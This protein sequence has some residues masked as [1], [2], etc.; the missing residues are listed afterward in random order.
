MARRV[1]DLCSIM[2]LLA[3]PDGRDHTVIGMPNG[4]PAQVPIGDLRVAF[5]TDNGIVPAEPETAAV[6]RQAAASLQSEVRLMQEHRPPGVEESYEHEMRLIGPDGGDGLRAY[7]ASIES[8]RTHPLLDGWLD[9]LEPYRTTVAGFA[10]YW[11]DLDR[12]R[13]RMLAF[14]ENYDAILSPVCANAALPHGRSIEERIFPGFS[15][16]M[17][18]N[19]TG[20]PAAV[21]RC[22]QTTDG[23]PIGVQI[24]AHPWRED[25]ALAIAARL[26]T[27][28][29]GW[30]RSVLLSQ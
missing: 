30:Q 15:Y 25:V 16:T 4:D 5:F 2:P 14:L 27:L 1:E 3:Q 20:W 23:L 12:F 21:V 13:A 26:E 18:Y 8:T 9:K 11:A 19:L 6:V 28:C 17:T 10:K 7:L 24:A 22:G 29:G